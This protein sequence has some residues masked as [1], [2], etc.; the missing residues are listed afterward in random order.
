MM[1]RAS[2]FLDKVPGI[3]GFWFHSGQ[4]V[5]LAANSHGRYDHGAGFDHPTFFMELSVFDKLLKL[6]T[7]VKFFDKGEGVVEARSGKSKAT[8][9]AKTPQMTRITQAG[10]LV[11]PDTHVPITP[12][13]AKVLNEFAEAKKTAAVVALSDWFVATDSVGLGA[14][15][16]PGSGVEASVPAFM[17]NKFDEDMK[18]HF[19]PGKVQVSCDG[20]GIFESPTREL[21]DAQRRVLRPLFEM[22][23]EPSVVFWTRDILDT[24]KTYSNAIEGQLEMKTSEWCINLTV[25]FHST[26][27]EDIVGASVYKPLH[28]CLNIHS[29]LSYISSLPKDSYVSLVDKGN[30]V[31][32]HSFSETLPD[33][34]V[35]VCATLAI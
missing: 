11:I 33:L 12:I 14:C 20:R 16:I 27:V 8:L 15:Y 28:C 5:A 24:L 4:I 1:K 19:S 35:A 3:E 29:I 31:R 30:F 10:A 22:S 7:E 21:A 9:K 32:L 2:V 13:Q 25:N 26:K 6:S 17:F 34:P 18:F 23:G